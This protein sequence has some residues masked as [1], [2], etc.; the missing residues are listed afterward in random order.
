MTPPIQRR[1]DSGPAVAE[2]RWRLMRLGLLPDHTHDPVA[3]AGA[4]HPAPDVFDDS[5]DE[6]VRHFQQAHGITVDGIVGA[7]TFRRLDE[8]RWRLGDRILSYTAGH[9]MSGDD[10][11]GLQHR[12]ID[13]GFD[14]RKVDGLFGPD[15]DHA[16]REF[17]RN[18]GLDPDGTCGPATFKALDR[19]VRAVT[20]GA[21]HTLHELHVWESALTGVADKVVVIDPGHGGYDTGHCH[22]HLTEAGVAWDLAQLV[23]GRLAAIG[24]QVLLTRGAAGHVPSGFLPADQ[25]DDKTPDEA[26][27]SQFA[28]DTGADLVVSLHADRAPSPRPSGVATFYYGHDR[29]GM[30]SPSGE[31]FAGLVQ[32]ELVTRTDFTD[33]HT[34]GKTWDILRLTRMPAVR[35]EC[36]YLSSPEDSERL[37]DPSFRESVADAI[38]AAIIRFFAPTE[39]STSPN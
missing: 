11:A 39:E 28:N 18:V 34:H 23:E 25:V 30:S 13:L 12:L 35:I 27:R 19:L 4:T 16:V 33:L 3:T 8:A 29:F 7:Q 22:G 37:A 21:A 6:A 5:L 32:E 14:L 2:I 1:G 17:Q 36:G 10:V 24:V 38:T 9:L 31:R 26:G 20:G 15:T